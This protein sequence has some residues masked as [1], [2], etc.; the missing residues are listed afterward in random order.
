MKPGIRRPALHYNSCCHLSMGM[1]WSASINALPRLIPPTSWVCCIAS[2]ALLGQL[3]N[4]TPVF[5]LFA[6]RVGCLDSLDEVI[7]SAALCIALGL[8]LL[9]VLRTMFSC[10]VER[11]HQC[12][13]KLPA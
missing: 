5:E 13:E 4:V 3:A 10:S 1:F 8:A 2:I 12:G 11:V 9:L 7:D 6:F